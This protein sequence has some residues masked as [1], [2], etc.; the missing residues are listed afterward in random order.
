M[1]RCNLFFEVIDLFSQFAELLRDRVGNVYLIEIINLAS[2]SP[3]DA[4]RDTDRRAVLRNV[5]QDNSTGGNFAVVRDGQRTKHLGAAADQHV[6]AQGGVP[7][8]AILAGTAQR[9]ALIE[10]AIVAD[11]GRLA[12]DNAHAVVYKKTLPD[13]SGGVYFNSGH[14]PRQLADRPGGQGMPG[15]VQLMCYAVGKDSMDAGV[16]Q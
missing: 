13:L 16:E 8:T 12:D 14:K 7:F 4:R 3:D 6:V 15:E 9:H 5:G 1:Q 2:V 11:L 10:R